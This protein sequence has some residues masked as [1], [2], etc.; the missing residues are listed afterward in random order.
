MTHEKFFVYIFTDHRNTEFGVPFYVGKGSGDRVMKHFWY[1]KHPNPHL[2][3]RIKAIEKSGS[4]VGVTVIDVESE[5]MAF[6]VEAALISLIGRRSLG[7]GPLCNLTDGGEGPAGMSHGDQAKAKISAT[8]A[9]RKQNPEVVEA[10]SS[11]LRGQTRTPEQRAKMSAAAKARF[12]DPA[13]RLAFAEARKLQTA[14]PEYRR[15]LSAAKKGIPPTAE[16]MAA[17]VAAR[18][19]KAE[20]RR[21]TMKE[22]DDA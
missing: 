16:V 2:G 5:A 17:S 13:K 10:R 18:K 19:A 11:K 21:L 6:E 15:R 3:R 12:A 4:R 20:R 7:T 9:G 22:I 14:D 8:H 1:K